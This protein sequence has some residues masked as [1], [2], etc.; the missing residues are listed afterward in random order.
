ML[1]PILSDYI[2]PQITSYILPCAHMYGM[3]HQK[4]LKT[5]IIAAILLVAAI[6][7]TT[8][9]TNVQASNN[10]DCAEKEI[11][12]ELL[13]GANE[14]ISGYNEGVSDGKRAAL[15]GESNDCPQ[16]NDASGYCLG[17]GSGWNRVTNAQE[18]LNDANSNDD[19]DGNNN[20]DDNNGNR[21]D[22]GE[23]V[24]ERVISQ[25]DVPKRIIGDNN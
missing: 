7:T 14:A 9:A 15:D 20:D 17:F 19:N 11:F 13:C 6:L 25:S 23:F 8:M 4:A 5:G 10:N 16:S 18:T 1:I 24:P 3:T 22:D 21:E 12:G 2:I